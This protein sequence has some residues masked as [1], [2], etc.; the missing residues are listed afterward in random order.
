LAEDGL[1][2]WGSSDDSEDCFGCSGEMPEEYFPGIL[3]RNWTGLS[4]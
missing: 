3:A 1:T 2:P 4:E